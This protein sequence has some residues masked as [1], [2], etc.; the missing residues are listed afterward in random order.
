MVEQASLLRVLLTRDVAGDEA[1][2]EVAKEVI[3]SGDSSPGPVVLQIASGLFKTASASKTVE[4]FDRV[5]EA[6]SLA[7]QLVKGE[8]QAQAKY[9]FGAASLYGAQTR[10][11]NGYEAKDCEAVKRG[12]DQLVD[13]Q[14]NLP[15]GGAFAPEAVPQLMATVMQLDQYADQ[16]IP[17]ICK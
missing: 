4:D 1:A 2:L 13:A 15:A 14:I 10:I 12:K 17:V 5:A 3:A 8:L 9:L 7:D 16:V 11:V 6:A